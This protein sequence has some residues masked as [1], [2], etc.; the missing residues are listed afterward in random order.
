MRA[1]QSGQRKRQ[2]C[3]NFQQKQ[4]SQMGIAP[5]PGAVVQIRSAN[6]KVIGVDVR[7]LG[8]RVVRC[9][10]LSGLTQDKE[11]SF[12]W[13]MEAD[14]RVLDPAAVELVLDASP[15]LIDTKLHLEA[16]FR[17]TPTTSREPLTLGRAAIDDLKFQ[18]LPVKMALGQ[19]RVRL[20]IADDVGLGKT[21]EAGLI[22]SELALRGRAGRIL[23]V[24]TRAMLTQFQKEFWTRFA[25]PLARLD[26]AAIRR[27]RNRIPAHYNVFDQFDRSIVSIDTLKK[28]AQ[29]RSALE[30]AYWDLIIIDEAHNAANRARSTGNTA[31]RAKLASLLSRRTDSLLLLTATPHDG[32]Q[33][34]FAS[35]VEMLDPTR[36]PDPAHLRREDIE[37]IVVRRFRSSPEIVAELGSIVPERKLVRRAIVLSPAEEAAYQAIAELRLDVDEEAARGR[38]IDLFRTTLAKAIF[39]SPVACLETLERRIKGIDA[40]TAR[41]TSNDRKRLQALA[42]EVR[43]IDTTAFSK[44]QDLLKALRDLKWTG[45]DA[46]DRLVIFSE[47]IATVAW[48]E[49]RLKADLGLGD[50]QVARVDGGS[51]EADTRTQQTIEAFGQERSPFRLLIASDMASEG[52]NLHF[53]CHRLIHFDLPWSLLRFQQR[54]GRIDRY[55]QDRSPE[56]AYFVAESTHPKVRQMWVLEKLVEKDVAA[57]QGVGDPAVFLG[58][59]DAEGEETVVAEAVAAGIGAEAF[60]AQMDARA[61]EAVQHASLDDEFAALF[62][63]YADYVAPPSPAVSS[64]DAPPRLFPDAFAYATAMLERLSAPNEGLF[65]VR[66]AVEPESRTIRLTLPQDMLARDGFGYSGEGEVDDRYMP[67]EAVGPGGR[68]ELTDEAQ[69]INHAIE[70][71]RI[72]ERSWPTVQYLWDGHPILEWFSD[73][74]QTFFP[75]HAAPVASLRGRL[76]PGEVAVVL[77]GAIPNARGAPV[78][79]RWAVALS[80]P[81]RELTIVEVGDF[82]KRVGLASDIPNSQ[83]PDLSRAREIVP[84]A[85]SRFQRHLVELRSAREGEIQ[86]GLDAV[87]ERLAALEGRFRAQLAESLGPAPLFEEALSLADRRRLALRRSREQRIDQLFKDWIDWFER[88]RRMV[89]DP[90]PHVDVKAVFVG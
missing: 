81:D 17:S 68:I 21:L 37:D 18:H 70:A 87:L 86:I 72:Q 44:Y 63:D 71:A 10:G 4:G 64:S 26:S 54:N 13:N 25:I 32:S 14:A 80:A 49:E 35:L 41:G 47:R 53:Q 45:R 20:L 9:R 65:P 67:K 60:A 29:I 56:I 16:G 73:Q 74:A 89:D 3:S 62:G 27:M 66:P 5:Q 7:S 78:V 39:S 84:W 15:G 85:V 48:L 8:Y 58:V 23:V 40:G 33:E 11:A 76:S 6:W 22:T 57:Q 79:D 2:G 59:G 1:E 69:V 42:D 77:H 88:T 55:G 36:V 90:N 38:A 43:A 82:M 31:L 50:E 34:S 12:I 83:A 51:V 19:D 61:A 30:T 46:R 24:T 52:L 75:D 28:D